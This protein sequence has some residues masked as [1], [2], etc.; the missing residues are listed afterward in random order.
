[1]ID[2]ADTIFIS[3]DLVVVNFL[4]WYFLDSPQLLSKH[5]LKLLSIIY[6]LAKIEAKILSALTQMSPKLD[7]GV[8]LP[9]EN[10]LFEHSL[11]GSSSFAD[12][13]ACHLI[14][15]RL[16]SSGSSLS[17]GRKSTTKLALDLH[18]HSLLYLTQGIELGRF[19]LI[20]DKA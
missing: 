2:V 18:D 10:Q 4:L 9:A 5:A 12:L 7:P 8:K 20:L 17:V 1:M 15:Q 13:P 14:A 11:E 16:L 6:L 19:H 3:V